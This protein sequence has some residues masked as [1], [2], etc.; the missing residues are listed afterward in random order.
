MNKETK[1]LIVEDMHR[2]CLELDTMLLERR[3]NGASFALACLL[4][5]A[6]LSEESNVITKEG[7]IEQAKAMWG[8]V[9]S[10]PN[11][12]GGLVH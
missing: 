7:F 9:E 11:E 2:I 3:H 8:A 6:K 4:V 12:S 10:V 1:K 5:S